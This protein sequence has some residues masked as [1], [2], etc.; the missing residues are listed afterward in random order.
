MT[1]DALQQMLERIPILTYHKIDPRREIGINS[2][3]PENFRLQL[4]FLHENGYQT[5]TFKEILE[6]KELPPKPVILSFDDAY[7]SVF[8]FAA[9]LMQEFNMRGIIFVISGFIGKANSWDANLGGLTFNHMNCRQLT[10]LVAEGWEVGAHTVT[11]RS[12]VHL[13]KNNVTKECL[14][15]KD[16]LEQKLETA[17]V[18]FAYPFGQQN[19][20]IRKAVAAAGYIFACAGAFHPDH[21]PRDLLKLPRY[22]VYQFESSAQLPD[23]LRLPFPPAFELLKLRLLN[24][25]AKMTP[26]YQRLFKREL[27]AGNYFPQDLYS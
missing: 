6:Q 21:G 27:F 19:A 24:F 17:V 12:L 15:A 11:H 25:P 2:L 3:S 8:D 4:Q 16:M 10:T 1:T 9:P 14:L 7:A 13:S 23:K 18:A 5:V 26:Y 20:A 22:S